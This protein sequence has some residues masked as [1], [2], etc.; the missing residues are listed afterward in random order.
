MA[1]VGVGKRK[2]VIPVH[3][4]YKRVPKPLKDVLLPCYIGTGCHYLSRLGTK[5][6]AINALPEKYLKN[7]V[8]KGLDNDQT[9]LAEEY[10][11]QVI[12]KDTGCKTFDEL[13]YSMYLK[14]L[15]I[16]H[17]PPTSHSIS[18][19]HIPRWWFIVRKLRSFLDRDFD[20]EATNYGWKNIDGH[21]FPNKEQTF[22]AC[23]RRS[24]Q[25][26]QLQSWHSYGQM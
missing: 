17:L 1:G 2:R 4:L 19:G 20:L 24:S 25:N 13:R 9:R 7:F 8:R 21:L 18:N 16:M 26:L 22:A 10:L 14:Q 3:S 23:S 12:K 6:A 11:V 5:L 15:D